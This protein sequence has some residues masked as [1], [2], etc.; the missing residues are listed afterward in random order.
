MFCE[1]RL[2]RSARVGEIVE[3]NIQTYQVKATSKAMLA[4]A[5]EMS[6]RR[7]SGPAAATAAEEV[8]FLL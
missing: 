1:L 8:L 5:Q 2:A 3:A 4:L 6:R 7:A